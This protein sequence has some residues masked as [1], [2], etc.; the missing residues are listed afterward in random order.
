MFR[1]FLLFHSYHRRRCDS[2]CRQQTTGWPE[3][4]FLLLYRQSWSDD[5][6]WSAAPPHATDRR[7]EKNLET[8]RPLPHI[9]EKWI[10]FFFY[11]FLAVY[12]SIKTCS[13]C[14]KIM[15]PRQ[16]GKFGYLCHRDPIR[17]LLTLQHATHAPSYTMYKN[18]GTEP[19]LGKW[20]AVSGS[21]W[22]KITSLL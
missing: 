18:G 21:S 10:L 1:H 14:C 7:S 22:V 3:Q 16:G 4:C 8:R 9:S 15:A 6:A 12:W 19:T 20:G 13:R 17:Y 11:V 2:L 5:L